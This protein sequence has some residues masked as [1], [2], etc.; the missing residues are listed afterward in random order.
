MSDKSEDDERPHESDSVIH[1]IAPQLSDE[2]NQQVD[3][4]SSPAFQCLDE[5]SNCKFTNK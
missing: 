4:L 2:E 1:A 5:V 3:V